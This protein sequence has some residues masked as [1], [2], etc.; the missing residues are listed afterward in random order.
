VH[1]LP[2]SV[3]ARLRAVSNNFGR[4]PALPVSS[5]QRADRGGGCNCIEASGPLAGGL[6]R[7]SSPGGCSCACHR[8]GSRRPRVRLRR[9]PPWSRSPSIPRTAPSAFPPDACSTAVRRTRP[10][11][12]ATPSSASER[13]SRR[14][15][16]AM[17]S[18]FQSIRVVP[19]C[20]IIRHCLPS[21]SRDTPTRHPSS[22]PNVPAH[23]PSS[24][25]TGISR[26]RGPSRHSSSSARTPRS[27]RRSGTPTASRCSA[28]A[29]MRRADPS[30]GRRPIG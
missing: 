7:R 9:P 18:A 26:R 29:A 15:S 6:G 25:I 22:G 27:C 5:K 17:A 1:V 24:A 30:T 10:H 28:S 14:R 12:A 23:A 16:P 21:T 8:A 3:K 13:S 19:R 20:Q 2:R 11:T 4:R